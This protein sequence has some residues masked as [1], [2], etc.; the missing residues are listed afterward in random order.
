M[1]FEQPTE[2]L[3][4]DVV[5]AGG[6]PAGL[7]AACWCSELGLDAILIEQEQGIGGQLNRIFAPVENYLGVKAQDGE[8]ML[9]RFRESSERYEFRRVMAAEVSSVDNSAKT[10]RLS[11]GDVISYESLIIATGVRRR[12][13]NISGEDEFA[14]KGVITSGVRDKETVRGK[15]VVIVGGGDAAIENALILSPLASSVTI[16]H[17]RGEFNAR[18]EFIASLGQRT[19][20]SLMMNSVLRRI[21]GDSTVRAVDLVETTSG[22]VS[23]HATDAVLIRI[24]VEPNSDNFRPLVNTDDRGYIQIDVSCETSVEGIFAAGDVANPRSPTISSA[25]GMGATAAKSAYSLIKI[26]RN[27]V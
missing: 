17:R 3:G 7:S 15:A 1:T 19:N 23:K 12:R 16:V 11:T 13:L 26:K 27:R 14:G 5:I 24:G 18:R 10:V 2:Q 21:D 4:A 20:I 25:T 9:S 8:D 22:T 6:G